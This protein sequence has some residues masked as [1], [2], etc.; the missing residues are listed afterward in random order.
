MK[1]ALIAFDNFQNDFPDSNLNHRI[2]FL[3]VEA[4]YKLAKKSIRNKQRERLMN[5]IANYQEFIDNYPESTLVRNAENI[6]I[7]CLDDLEKL[8]ENNL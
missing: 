8:Q 4:S 3:K 1:A 7:D 6:Y 5:T 2:S